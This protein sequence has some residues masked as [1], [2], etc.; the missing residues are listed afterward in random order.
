MM[1]TFKKV[2]NQ[3]WFVCKNMDT[4]LEYESKT[5]HSLFRKYINAIQREE[6]EDNTYLLAE[7]LAMD[8]NS[9]T[10]Q[11]FSEFIRQSE[12]KKR[13]CVEKGKEIWLNEDGGWNCGFPQEQVLATVTKRMLLF[14]IYFVEDIRIKKFM[15][16][17][18]GTHF[19]A[20]VGNIEVCE[21]I[22]GEKK[23]KWDTY[24]EAYEKALRYCYKED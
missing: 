19:Y 7:L 12:L 15:G 6:K 8:K 14:P 21:F 22:N 1:Y 11:G 9:T 5:Y 24:E 10:F 4:L 2:N 23:I 20:Y 18:K 3:W 13:A 17:A 16:D